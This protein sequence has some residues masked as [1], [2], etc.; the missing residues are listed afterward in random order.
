MKKN[1]APGMDFLHK[2]SQKKTKQHCRKTVDRK[3]LVSNIS[4]QA[5]HISTHTQTHTHTHTHTRT[6]THTHTR[7]GHRTTGLQ[8]SQSHSTSHGPSARQISLLLIR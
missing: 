5:K 3:V 7:R 6:H 8:L 4:R 2:P 1:I